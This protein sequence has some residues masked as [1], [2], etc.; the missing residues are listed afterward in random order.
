MAYILFEFFLHSSSRFCFLQHA[1]IVQLPSLHFLLLLSP[2]P[3]GSGTALTSYR[4][5][6]AGI[7][8]SW[9]SACGQNGSGCGLNRSEWMHPVSVRVCVVSL[10]LCICVRVCVCVQECTLLSANSNFA[11]ILCLAA[12]GNLLVLPFSTLGRE[13]RVEFQADTPTPHPFPLPPSLPIAIDLSVCR[14]V[15]GGRG[16]CLSI[17]FG[18]GAWRGFPGRIV[19]DFW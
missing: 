9:V 6:F 7:R 19:T 12:S 15:V 5:F 16:R 1:A 17:H 2:S 3:C 10:C 18:D 11:T 14:R 4:N 13:L 8:Y